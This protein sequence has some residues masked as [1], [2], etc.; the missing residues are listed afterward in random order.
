M[1]EWVM[2]GKDCCLPQLK[3]AGI[4]CI[5]QAHNN[6]ISSSTLR[7]KQGSAYQ[8]ETTLEY[9]LLCTLVKLRG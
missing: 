6:I 3:S 4:P 5:T 1:L 9:V 2:L 7:H 8:I